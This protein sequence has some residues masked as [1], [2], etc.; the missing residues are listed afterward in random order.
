MY[1]GGHHHSLKLINLADN[2]P[3]DE[4][5]D[6]IA[7]KLF[8]EKVNKGFIDDGIYQK[9]ATDL[10]T[11]MNS[12]LGGQTF[13]FEDPRNTLKAYFEQNIYSFSAAKSLTELLQFR[14][15]LTDSEGNKRTFV[16]FRNAV[17][18]AGYQFNN[19]WLK[20]EYETANAATQSAAQWQKFI[21]NGTEYLEYTTVGDDKVRPAHAALNGFT[22]KVDDPVWNIIYPPNDW[23]CRCW[24]IP[25]IAQNVDLVNPDMTMERENIPPLFQKNI[26]QT[27]VIFSKDHP[28]YKAGGANPEELTAVR[29]YGMATIEQLYKKYEFPAKIKIGSTT[30][31]NSWWTDQAPGV[32]ADFFVKDVNGV[33]VKMDD[34]FRT[35]TLDSDNWTY[36]ANIKDVLEAPDEVWSIR[37]GDKLDRYYVKYYKES[38]V[39][40]SVV[41]LP[42][43]VDGMRA[44]E[45][46]TSA[47]LISNIRRGTLI[48]KKQ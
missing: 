45:L 8:T 16:E 30:E 12:G 21:E 34:A 18:D 22:A 41:S 23:S 28:Y 26:G 10:L 14:S 46:Q 25:G 11:A 40:V 19:N 3:F 13:S 1:E 29:N 6:S 32:R 7:E 17:I 33:V 15:L 42:E 27:K 47:K 43:L 2:G 36:I 9:T 20:T 37:I 4:L 24:V 44:E 35:N 31:A 38:P 48:Y 5:L 39:V